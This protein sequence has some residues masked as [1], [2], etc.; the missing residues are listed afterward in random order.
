MAKDQGPHVVSRA[1]L[2]AGAAAKREVEARPTCKVE[3]DELLGLIGNAALPHRTKRQTDLD[4]EIETS[5]EE[6]VALTKARSNRVVQT[7][8]RTEVAKPSISEVAKGSDVSI[9][10]V[11]TTE[12][13]E[14][15]GLEESF[16][17]VFS[18]PTRV[19]P[20]M[21]EAPVEP[22]VLASG[23]AMVPSLTPTE[24]PPISIKLPSPLVPVRQPRRRFAPNLVHQIAIG[25][26]L[27]CVGLG[28]Y[29]GIIAT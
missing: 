14:I 7:V 8:R 10:V 16:V 4:V 1:S 12:P 13:M 19:A 11:V 17:D 2:K 3:K 23:S 22:E 26:V 6:T 29:L 5:S 25:V 20:L 18:Q 21:T 9:P 15:E 28:V 27:G 24:L